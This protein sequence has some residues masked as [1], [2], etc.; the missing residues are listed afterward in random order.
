MKENEP[1]KIFFP[2]FLAYK[3]RNP[4]Y[5]S[6]DDK[7]YYVRDEAKEGSRRLDIHQPFWRS[8][9]KKGKIQKIEGNIFI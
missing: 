8:I 4:I 5:L 1:R 7:S 3:K 2:S 9:D 6:K